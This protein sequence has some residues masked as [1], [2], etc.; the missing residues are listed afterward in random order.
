V[1][2]SRVDL[3]S[4]CRV[5]R[6]SRP[7]DM[8]ATGQ[9]SVV[10]AGHRHRTRRRHRHC[11]TSPFLSTCCRE[12]RSRSWTFRR[13]H[14][15]SL[16]RTQLH[17]SLTQRA[18]HWSHTHYHRQ[19]TARN[20]CTRR[21]HRMQTVQWDMVRRR[22]PALVSFMVNI[23]VSLLEPVTHRKH[24]ST[25]SSTVSSAYCISLCNLSLI[26]HGRT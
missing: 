7:R 11:P 8:L 22:C 6:Y 5:D 18:C 15:R 17:T 21:Q 1:V 10:H 16:C 4:V 13:C 26:D 25:S 23:M 3:V 9:E 14:D 20:T 19:T 12:P 2:D 24:F